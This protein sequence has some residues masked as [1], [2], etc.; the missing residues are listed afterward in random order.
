MMKKKLH[1]NTKIKDKEIIKMNLKKLC[2]ESKKCPFVH[3]ADNEE[4]SFVSTDSLNY[5]SINDKLCTVY[6]SEHILYCDKD[7]SELDT[8]KEIYPNYYIQLI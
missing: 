5:I 2:Y 7:F 1:Y 3:I 4:D 6:K 8:I